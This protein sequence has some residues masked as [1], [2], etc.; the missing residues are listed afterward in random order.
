MDFYSNSLCLFILI[1][2]LTNKFIKNLENNNIIVPRTL[3]KENNIIKI[4]IYCNSGDRIRFIN[5]ISEN[6]DIKIYDNDSNIIT[7]N[8]HINN[9]IMKKNINYLLKINFLIYFY[10][11]NNNMFRKIEEREKIFFKF[12]TYLPL[13]SGLNTEMMSSAIY[14]LAECSN[15][16]PLNTSILIFER[17]D[18]VGDINNINNNNSIIIN[19][20][21]NNNNIN[22]NFNNNNNNNNIDYNNINNNINFNINNNINNNNNINYNINNNNININN[23]IIYDYNLNTNNLQE[24]EE[25]SFLKMLQNYSSL[26]GNIENQICNYQ[27]NLNNSFVNFYS[28]DDNLNIS[29]EMENKKSNLNESTKISINGN[30]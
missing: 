2:L 19:N 21:N 27:E 24:N 22:N 29:I 25:N 26:E 11:L 6:K 17:N 8:I 1:F 16:F 18:S 12:L 20:N 3:N 10:G 4:K 30:H 15:I 14:S 9:F 28:N 23:N 7:E 13:P 5:F